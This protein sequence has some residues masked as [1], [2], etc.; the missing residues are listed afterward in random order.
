MSNKKLTD[1]LDLDLEKIITNEFDEFGGHFYTKI[2]ICVNVDFND[3]DIADIAVSDREYVFSTQEEMN[4]FS[5][6]LTNIILDLKR[7]AE[8]N[9]ET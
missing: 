8:R 9:N 6:M 2:R 7:E 1:I 4:R 5:R 3:P